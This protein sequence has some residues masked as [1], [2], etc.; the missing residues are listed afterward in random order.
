MEFP[1]TSL[2]YAEAYLFASAGRQ[3]NDRI[4][5]AIASYQDANKAIE[6]RQLFARAAVKTLE[7]RLRALGSGGRFGDIPEAELRGTPL[8]SFTMPR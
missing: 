6:M 8:S 3:I 2:A 4:D 7:Q 5:E 1:V